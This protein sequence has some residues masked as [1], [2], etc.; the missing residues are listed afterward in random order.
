MVGAKNMGQE[1]VENTPFLGAKPKFGWKKTTTFHN[2]LQYLA[3]KKIE[4]KHSIYHGSF[5]LPTG[6]CVCVC[7]W[8]RVCWFV[9]QKSIGFLNYSLS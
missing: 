1:M 2:Q 3:G 9:P 8:C 7:W 5:L 4:T 6:V